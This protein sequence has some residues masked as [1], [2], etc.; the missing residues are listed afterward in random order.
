LTKQKAESAESYAKDAESLATSAYNSLWVVYSKKR[1][2]AEAITSADT[3]VS[4]M[5]EI[6]TKMDFVLR[7][8]EKYG[9]DVATTKSVYTEAKQNVDSAEDL[10]SQSKNRL[11]AGYNDEA[12][13][14]A[15]ESRNKA[16]S[17][18]NR[19]DT[20]VS[21]LQVN[22]KQALDKAFSEVQSKLEDAKSKADNA[23][24]T[25]G[26]DPD[27][28]LK[29][30]NDISTA[31]Q[32]M[33]EVSKKIE[34]VQNAEDLTGLLSVAEEAFKLLGDA[35]NEIASGVKNADEAVMALI[36][37]VGAG[38]A[39]VASLG[40]GGFL[41]WRRKKKR[42]KEKPK[43]KKIKKEEDKKTKE[44]ICSKC[45][46]KLAEDDN[47]CPKCGERME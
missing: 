20:M 13:N 9:V 11:Q 34:L 31:E 10:L 7:D 16:A 44:R 15:V 3:E 24:N 47:F 29:A 18:H 6:L 39:V 28:V 43:Q 45:K 30:H 8:M 38:A 25:Y 46:I 19:L 32:M 40:G 23:A 26:A 17:S 36:R 12:A 21:T 42:S 41:Y 22:I 4:Q 1:V 27:A 37:N 35:E 2:A 14:L 5:N 33:T